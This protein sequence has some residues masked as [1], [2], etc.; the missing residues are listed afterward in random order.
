MVAAMVFEENEAL[1]RR[2][3]TREGRE[4]RFEAEG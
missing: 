2:E 4:W 3:M 1:R